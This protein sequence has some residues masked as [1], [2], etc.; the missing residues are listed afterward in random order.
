M[1]RRTIL[2]IAA[3]LVAALGTVLVWMYANRAEEAALAGQ[4]PVQVLVA[5]TNIA[6]GTTGAAISEAGTAELRNLP[7]S[8]VPANALGDLT[9]V[10]DQ[11]AVSTI[12]EG[13]VLVAGM[14]GS[15]QAAGG[16]LTLPEGALA[17]S[18]SLGDPQRVAG[19]LQPGSE[20]AVFV[21]VAGATG[22]D[23][24]AADDEAAAEAAGQ[25]QTAVLLE[26]VPIVAVGPTT[27]SSTTT[28]DGQVTNTEQIPTA[29]LTLALDQEQA[30]RVIQASTDGQLY[31]GL[32]NDESQVD[33]NLPGTTTETLLD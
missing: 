24:P 16:G 8:S 26:R 2:L 30:Q 33:P 22:G 7:A 28:T 17:V 27:V 31:F 1:G 9:P 18:V 5:T 3:L 10:A 29:I 13:Q 20:V 12:F 15:V 21:T 19:F 14:F 25:T 23:A 6:A 4:E 11:V 32:L